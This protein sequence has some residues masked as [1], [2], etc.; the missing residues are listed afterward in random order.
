MFKWKNSFSAYRRDV[1]EGSRPDSYFSRIT[2][3]QDEGISLIRGIHIG[4]TSQ[5]F[6]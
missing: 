2:L 6:F 1:E 5:E 3:I 4:M